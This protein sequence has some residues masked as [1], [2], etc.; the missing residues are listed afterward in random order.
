MNFFFHTS[1]EFLNS[2]LEIPKFQNSGKIDSKLCLFQADI[3]NE[4]W[5]F[6]QA[7]CSEC[8]YF[9]T[10]QCNDQNKNSIY[11]LATNAQIE[12]V[13]AH[14][15]LINLNKFTDT[16]PDFRANLQIINIAGAISSYQSEYPFRMTEQLGNLYSDCGVLTTNNAKKVGVFL[17]N[18]HKKPIQ[19]E[20]LLYLYDNK[21]DILLET[22]KIYLNRTCYVDLTSFKKSL[23]TCFIYANNYLGIPVYLIE[24]SSGGLSFEHTHP[25]HES[26]QGKNRY[27]LVNQLKD[28]AY[29]KISST[30]I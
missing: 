7:N 29:E 10:I 25:P 20:T 14:N 12:I 6:S 26:I 23:P 18:I 8:E 24:Y 21:K 27:L 1:N 17:R 4:K 2:K 15:T 16:S 22:F 5:H 3:I 30:H 28:R 19:Q 9:W 13:K 11:F